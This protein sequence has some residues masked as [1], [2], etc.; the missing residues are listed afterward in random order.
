VSVVMSIEKKWAEIL[1]F[2]RVM[3]FKWTGKENPDQPGIADKRY[4]FVVSINNSGSTA[5]RDALIRNDFVTGFAHEGQCLTRYAI[6]SVAFPHSADLSPDNPEKVRMFTEDEDQYVCGA[7]YDWAA[8][9]R[10]W[11]SVWAINPK[12]RQARYL[13]EKSPPSV[14]WAREAQGVFSP[15]YFV[16]VVREPYATCGSIKGYVGEGFAERIARHWVRCAELQRENLHVLKHS[17]LLRYEDFCAG[18]LDGVSRLLDIDLTIDG[19]LVRGVA[20]ANR[21]QEQVALLT[22]QESSVI[23]GVLGEHRD[24]VESFGYSV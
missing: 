5:V 7:N 2:E 1:E 8:V 11:E 22:E 16:V 4:L 6:P 15:S 18:V 20:V 23:R 12:Y 24:L 19:L 17:C 21:N 10:V 9:V 14:F 3:G 13:V